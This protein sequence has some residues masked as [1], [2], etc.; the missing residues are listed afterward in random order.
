MLVSSGSNVYN[1]LYSIVFYYII[2]YILFY[3]SALSLPLTLTSGWEKLEPQN[4]VIIYI[5]MY[6]FKT[7]KS[8]FAD[9]GI[10]LLTLSNVDSTAG[11]SR[12]TQYFVNF[13]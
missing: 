3:K 9:I 4:F 11:R 7:Y 6:A 8:I 2:T 1:L 13:W 5:I 10:F 12:E